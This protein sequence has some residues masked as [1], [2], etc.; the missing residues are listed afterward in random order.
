MKA[1]NIV[2]TVSDDDADKAYDQYHAIV[3]AL[4]DLE[5]EGVLDFPFNTQVHE[6]VVEAVSEGV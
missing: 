2:I 4:Q 3:E 1:Y 6:T 5:E